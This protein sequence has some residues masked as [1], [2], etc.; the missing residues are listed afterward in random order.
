[1]NLRASFFAA[2][3]GIAMLAC[4]PSGQTREMRMMGEQR[5]YR[6]SVEPMPPRA[7]EPA[8]FRVVVRDKETGQP[9]QGGEGRIFAT[10]VDGA[11]TDDGLAK[12]EEV[13][14]Y[15]GRLFFVTAGDWAMALQ[16]R[17]DS[18][19]RLERVDWMQTVLGEREVG[20]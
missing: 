13:G 16:F 11:G 19:E 15:Y 3:V 6:I 4:G 8:R 18:T 20:Q 10:S 1:L 2:G 5:N 9:V 7:L 14:T 12:G 17:E